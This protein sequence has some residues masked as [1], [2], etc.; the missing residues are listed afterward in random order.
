MQVAATGIV[1]SMGALRQ[2]LRKLAKFCPVYGV[3]RIQNQIMG[4]KHRRK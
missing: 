3:T 2:I 4:L 1:I